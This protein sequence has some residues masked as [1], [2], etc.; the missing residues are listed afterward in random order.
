MR[1]ALER[2]LYR[3]SQSEHSVS[4]LLKG[5]TLF[6]VWEADPHR[7]TR[8][9]DLLS[10]GDD[11]AERLRDVFGDVCSKDVPDDG[12]VF[13]ER[14]IDVREIREGQSYGGK[15]VVIAA[16][17]GAMRLK[18]QADIGFGDAVARPQDA[19]TMPVM[20]GF[21]PPTLRT[22][23]AEAV[24]AEKLHAMV[25]H[26]ML[27]SRM[28]DV[29]DVVALAARLEF[30][31]A[32][33]TDAIRRTFERRATRIGSELPPPATEAFAADPV[34]RRRW[35]GFLR[36]NRIASIT[37]DEAVGSLRTFLS[38]PWAALAQ[39]EPFSWRWPAGGPW[40]PRRPPDH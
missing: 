1:F 35:G 20:L 18:V 7:S 26:G 22:Y 28:K 29:Y 30:D 40:S 27:N 32:K 12:M 13:D 21:P 6:A 38:K 36:R 5:A 8:D 17:L 34:M 31:G 11:S 39:G 9:I 4:F 24:I 19:V 10:F 33:L 25:Q 23:P 16:R 3:L 14:T 15:R 2:F 37:L